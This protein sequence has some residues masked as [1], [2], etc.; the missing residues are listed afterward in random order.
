M[1]VFSVTESTSTLSWQVGLPASIT[2]NLPPSLK[3][4][5]WSPRPSQWVILQGS[6]LIL[7]LTYVSWSH[8]E[9]SRE[10]QAML[11]E[12][13]ILSF[14]LC[15]QIDI[16]WLCRSIHCALQLLTSHDAFSWL[17]KIPYHPKSSRCQYVW[18]WS[19]KIALSSDL[20]FYKDENSQMTYLYHI[21]KYLQKL[22]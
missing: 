2:D 8:S 20:F 19:I 5:I 11:Q 3:A 10:V 14:L 22:P 15:Y 12:E 17:W 16:L 9:L 4:F 18:A 21:F 7:L 1:F 13:L 6:C